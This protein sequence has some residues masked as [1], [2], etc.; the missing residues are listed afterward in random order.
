MNKNQIE[1]ISI[2]G[3]S[4]HV[5]KFIVDELLTTGKHKITAISREDSTSEMPAGVEVKKVNYDDQS[6]LVKALQG[7]DMLIITMSVMAPR[8]SESKLVEAAAEANVPWI[9]PNEW[10]GDH[11]DAQLVQDI[12]IGQSKLDNRAHIEKLGKSSW[13]GL[14]CGFWY[15]YSLSFSPLLY[16]FD[17]VNRAVTFY[18]DGNTS[19]NTSTWAQCGRAVASLLSLKV[20]RD[21]EDDESPCLTNFKNESVYISSFR[22]SQRDMLSSVMRVTN[23][24]EQ[25][26]KVEYEPTN[27]RFKAGQEQFK[28]GDRAGFAKL[29]YARVFYPDGSGDFEAKHVLSNDMLG[30]P[31]ENIDEATKT[32]IKM[33][34]QIYASH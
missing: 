17:F 32:A 19:I 15:E 24:A 28:K 25:D 2:V 13:V 11:T 29:L 3:A 30:L 26:W 31:K 12:I 18:D 33:A 16:G 14:T 27:E 8:D 20:H 10:G 5:G 34:E 7:T 4:G 22:V 1:N 6:S 9:M 23:T 21:S